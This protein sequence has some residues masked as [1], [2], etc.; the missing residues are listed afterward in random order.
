MSD[1][2]LARDKFFREQIQTNKEG[3][4]N[5]AHFLNCNKV[6]QLKIT[7]GDIATACAESDEVEV[8]TDKLKVRRAGNKALPEKAEAKK[9]EGK[10][11]DKAPKKKDEG[12]D[13]YDE[14]TGKVILTE[15]DFSDPIIVYFK[16]TLAEAEEYK[17]NWKEVE[18]K[19]KDTYPK[20]KLIYSRGGQHDGHMAFSSLRLN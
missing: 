16:V 17:V 7:A 2:N 3:W 13:E 1:L 9:R 10:A 8:S 11:E 15:R 14:K 4:V 5:I 6:K 12:V 19:V 18:A 20:L